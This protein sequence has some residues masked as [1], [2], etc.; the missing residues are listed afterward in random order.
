[1]PE[2]S[3]YMTTQ[4]VLISGASIAGCVVILSFGN[5]LKLKNMK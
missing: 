2:L 3:N 1:M 5:T 4:V